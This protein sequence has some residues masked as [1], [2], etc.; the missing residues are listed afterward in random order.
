MYRSTFKRLRV[1]VDSAAYSTPAVG[2]NLFGGVQDRFADEST[3]I[4]LAT[5][6]LDARK[7]F[8]LKTPSHVQLEDDLLVSRAE[9][10][11]NSW[12]G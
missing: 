5:Q 1:V 3:N 11:V 12:L 2:E 10:P 4:D 9:S 7:R 8:M 6:A